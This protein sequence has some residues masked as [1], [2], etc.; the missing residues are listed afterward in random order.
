[1]K[2]IILLMTVWCFSSTAY[3]A[4]TDC[5]SAKVLHIQIEYRKVLYRQEGAPWRAL[6]LLNNDDGTRERYAALLA[7]QAAGRPVVIGYAIDGYDCN[8]TNYGTSAF[9]L[10]TH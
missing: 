9:L 1:M 8:E 5:P 4:R 2:R 3:S 10:R 6:G 7:A